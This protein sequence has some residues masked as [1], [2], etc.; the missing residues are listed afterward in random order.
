MPQ[1]Q[2]VRVQSRL[3]QARLERDLK[4]ADSISDLLDSKFSVGGI[5]FGLDSIIGLV[6]GVG[7][8]ATGLVSLYPVYLAGRHEL[9]A[10]T[11]AK[12]LGNV[13]VD[14]VVGSVPLLGDA[15]D[16]AFKANRRNFKLLREAAIKRHGPQVVAR[17]TV[18]D[19]V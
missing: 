15:F 3:G 12:M 14:A 9:G 1:T 11:I 19:A 4:I 5:R 16:V 18:V 7:D 2:R 8:V 10:G 17:D 13:A 6:P